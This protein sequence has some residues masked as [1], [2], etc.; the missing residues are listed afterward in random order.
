MK[1]FCAFA[2]SKQEL[3]IDFLEDMNKDSD[4]FMF[5]F[6]TVWCPYPEKYHKSQNEMNDC[7]FAHNWQDF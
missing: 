2:H 4:F 1:D 3:K 7:V 6:K 5:H